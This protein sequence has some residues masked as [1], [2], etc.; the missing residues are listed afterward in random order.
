[1]ES[2]GFPEADEIGMAPYMTPESGVLFLSHLTILRGL[3]NWNR[4]SIYGQ[5]IKNSNL[6]SGVQG[7]WEY[8]TTGNGDLRLGVGWL[9]D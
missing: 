3:A 8:E 6:A 4:P 9:R 1:M 5:H 7:G 2:R